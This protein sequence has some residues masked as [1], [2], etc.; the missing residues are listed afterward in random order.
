MRIQTLMLVMMS[1]QIANL[2][3][4]P[5][6]SAASQTMKT[7][8]LVSFNLHGINSTKTKASQC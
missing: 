5:L 1:I 8:S 7:L 3:N 2:L 6:D 4:K